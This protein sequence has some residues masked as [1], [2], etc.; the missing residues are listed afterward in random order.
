MSMQKHPRVATGVDGLDQLL[1]GGLP[2]GRLYVVSGPPGSGKTTFSA[3]FTTRGAV[4]GENCLYLTMHETAEEL[5]TDLGGYEFGFDRALASDRVTLLNVLDDDTRRLLKSR[6]GDSFTSGVD[7]MTNRL[8]NFMKTND[9]DRF[10]VDSTMLLDYYFDEDSDV[11]LQFLTALKRIDATTIVISEM[12][13]PSS[14]GEEHYLAHG[15]LFFHN[16]LEDSGMTRG[17]QVTKM[18]GTAIDGEMR[19]LSFS[20]KGLEVDPTEQIATGE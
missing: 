15:V 17:V 8:R 18:R 4:N 12:T 5:A 16:F 1:D 14:Y 9:F 7:V 20:S 6:N 11:L 13:D 2:A 3:H 10:V 19:P